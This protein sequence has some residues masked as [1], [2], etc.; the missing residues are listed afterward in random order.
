MKNSKLIQ[1]LATFDGRQRRA[2]ED[3]VES[4]YFNKQEELI[5]FY[6]YLKKISSKGFSPKGLDRY[7]L[8]QRLFP[9][10]DYNE[11]HLNYLSSQLLKLAERYIGISS[12]E[13]AA[14]LPEYFQLHYFV[15]QRLEKHYQYNMSQAQRKLENARDDTEQYLYQKYL[16]ADLREKH[17]SSLKQRRFD[18]NLQQAADSF[19][20]FYLFKKLYLLCAMLDRQNVVTPS[21]KAQFIPE[22]QSILQQHKFDDPAIKTLEQLLLSLTAEDTA[23]HF[24]QLRSYL[25]QY[26]HL[27]SPAM[28]RDLYFS[29][30]NFC[31]RKIR[32]GEKDYATALMSIYQEGIEKGVL[33][34]DGYLSPWT[35]KNLVK[36]GIGLKA[37]DWTKTFIAEYAPK[38]PPHMQEDALHFNLADLYYALRDYDQAQI[39]LRQVEFSDVQYSFGAKLT[40]TKIYYETGQTE[41]LYS[42]LSSF[43]IFLQRKKLITKDVKK[44]YLNFIQY[45]HRLEKAKPDQLVSLEEKINSTEMLTA[46]SWLLGQLQ[47]IKS[48]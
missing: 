8:Y 37:Y 11:K 15:D 10:S 7:Q 14:V 47:K 1:I 20:Q 43:K 24:G 2:F 9:K 45:V 44:P 6:K 34:E 33:F 40:L 25:G 23:H 17:F 5:H 26:S 22:I 36:L 41:A 30:I 19:D 28:L 21:Y 42:L 3:F 16:L 46:R 27:F 31:I 12:F 35:F 4:P 18:E 48:L 38:L 29:I 13:K 32:F 39:H